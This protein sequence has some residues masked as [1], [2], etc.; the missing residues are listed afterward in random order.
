MTERPR[1]YIGVSGVINTPQQEKLI[2]QFKQSDLD[3][4]RYLALGVKA[5]HKTQFLDQENKYGP[6]WYPV[7]AQGFGEALTPQVDSL[8]V[9]Q[10]FLDPAHVSDRQYRYEFIDR[11]H[12]RGAAWLDAVQFDMLPWQQDSSLVPFFEKIKYEM[13]LKIL[14]QAHNEPM[15]SLGPNKLTGALGRYAHVLDYV[16]FDASHGNGVRMSTDRLQP[17]LDVAY[18]SHELQAV[19]LGVAGGLN[20]AVVREDLPALLRDYPDLSWDAEGQLHPVNTAGKRPLDMKLAAEYIAA[21]AEVLR[22][23]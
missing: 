3:S 19:G 15:Q 23:V 11:V 10:L 22:S 21:S 1:P 2:E 7:G 16:L 17:F 14:L 8:N 5:T 13:G 18:Q 20:S 6:E 9:A 4:S 12:R